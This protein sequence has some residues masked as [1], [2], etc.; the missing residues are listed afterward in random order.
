[1]SSRANKELLLITADQRERRRLIKVLGATG[2][3]TRVVEDLSDGRALLEGGKIEL[4]VVDYGMSDPARWAEVRPGF[5]RFLMDVSVAYGDKIKILLISDRRVPQE[6]LELFEFSFFTNLMAKNQALGLDELIITVAKILDQD[7]FG[8]EKYL[9]YGVEAVGHEV[10][11]SRDKDRLLDAFQ[12]YCQGIGIH[13]RLIAVAKGVADEFLMNAVY[14]APVRPD[15]QRPYASCPR[16]QAVD[17][18]PDEHALFRYACDG[19][20]LIL[21]VFD[22]FG[23][24][25]PK[26]VLGYLRRCFAR[27]P[28][29]IEEKAGGAG[30]GLYF[31]V[32]S[33]N[34]VVINIQPGKGT[35][36]IGLIDISGSFRDYAGQGKSFHIFM[37]QSEER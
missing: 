3:R 23:S 18:R 35:E 25:D 20:H 26:V 27:G 2:C 6:L 15:G 19:R 10:Q 17:L 5:D 14:N 33:L 29:Q 31:I 24:L 1:M 22:R 36:M 21:S 32:E 37:G 13:R 11:S 7:L 30:M 28:D 34:K 16:S 12:S 9:C 4:L 8:L